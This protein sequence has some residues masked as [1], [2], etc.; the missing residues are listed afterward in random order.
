MFPCVSQC[1]RHQPLAL[2][3]RINFSN[4][5]ESKMHCNSHS[6]FETIV[7]LNQFAYS[8]N[9]IHNLIN[10]FIVCYYFA[11]N[12]MRHNKSTERIIQDVMISWSVV[13][14]RKIYGLRTIKCKV[15]PPWYL[16]TIRFIKYNKFPYFCS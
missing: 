5:F 11:I 15:C 8:T 4:R 14:V 10:C 16:N 12:F 7:C 2:V 1:S 6:I 13:N 3:F 9:I